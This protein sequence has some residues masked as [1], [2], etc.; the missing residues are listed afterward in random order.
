MSFLEKMDPRGSGIRA[1]LASRP[2][3]TAYNGGSM[4]VTSLANYGKKKKTI[5]DLTTIVVLRA[6]RLNCIV[7]L[8]FWLGGERTKMKRCSTP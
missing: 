1:S 4:T 7:L 5:L 2:E 3:Y 8:E 6:V